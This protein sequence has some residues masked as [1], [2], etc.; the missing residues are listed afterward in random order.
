MSDVGSWAWAERTGGRLGRRDRVHLMRQGIAA[1]VWRLP[2]ALRDR[3]VSGGAAIEPPAPPDT[4]LA[5]QAEERVR[6]LSTPALYGHCMRTW[7]FAALFAARNRVDHDAELLYAAAVLHDLGLTPAHTARDATAHCFAVEGA[8]A[9]H[10]LLMT[11]G[12]P[13]ASARTVAEAISLHLNVDV[14][15]GYGPIAQLLS[16]GVMLDVVGRRLS[17]SPGR[18]CPTSWHVGRATDRARPSST[19]RNARRSCGPTRAPRYSTDLDSPISS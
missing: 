9:A 11:Q 3:L 15:A 7:A 1:R 12:A 5:R 14:A 19:T 2:V 6:E 10:G 18:P 16:H 17:G 4:S 8:R 13:E